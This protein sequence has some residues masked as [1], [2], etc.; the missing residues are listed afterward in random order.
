MTKERE[1]QKDFEYDLDETIEEL[2][3]W[4]NRGERFYPTDTTVSALYWLDRAPGTTGNYP[5][6]FEETK[7]GLRAWLADE[8]PDLPEPLGMA[9]LYWLK[10]SRSASKPG[11]TDPEKSPVYP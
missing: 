8:D 11:G 1:D 3:G 10:R 9:A 7:E 6:S 2:R 4:L 5:E